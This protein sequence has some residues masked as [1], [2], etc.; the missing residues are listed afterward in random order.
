MCARNLEGDG[1][2]IT[3]KIDVNSIFAI[4]TFSRCDVRVRL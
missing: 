4:F 3:S 1:E 2:N